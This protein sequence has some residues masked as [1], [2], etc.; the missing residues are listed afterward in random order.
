MDPFGIGLKEITSTDDGVMDDVHIKR[1]KHGADLVVLIIHDETYCGA[2]WR[3]KKFQLQRFHFVKL[4]RFYVNLKLGPDPAKMF[5]VVR[6]SCATGYYS[7]GH[8]IAHNFVS[9]EM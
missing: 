2:A 9:F 5:S 8:E 6:H 4:T 1:K 3:G 7:F